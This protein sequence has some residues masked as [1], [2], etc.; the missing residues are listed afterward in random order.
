MQVQTWLV[1]RWH[2]RV[3]KTE[4]NH[5]YFCEGHNVGTQTLS[6]NPNNE[7]SY[8]NAIDSI[9]LSEAKD[10]SIDRDYRQWKYKLE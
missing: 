7:H 1:W 5:A 8:Y 4:P 6:I 2:D 9:I 10:D 3:V